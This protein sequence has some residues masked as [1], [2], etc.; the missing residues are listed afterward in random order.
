MS[1]SKKS[2]ISFF[3]LYLLGLGLRKTIEDVYVKK[4]GGR[5]RRRRRKPQERFWSF[6]FIAVRCRRY[7]FAGKQAKHSIP[8]IPRSTDV[9]CDNTHTI[10]S[11]PERHILLIAETLAV[12]HCCGI[13]QFRIEMCGVKEKVSG[14]VLRR[15]NVD[16][17]TGLSDIEGIRRLS[18]AKIESYQTLVRR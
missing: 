14:F 15:E 13:I 6:R 3:M 9:W 5:H 2:E 11:V 4:G 7:F 17:Q 16:T 10:G 18:D 12:S 8:R 1:F